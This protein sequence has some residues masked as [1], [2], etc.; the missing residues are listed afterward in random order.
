M[1]KWLKDFIQ[2]VFWM[3]IRNG[4]GQVMNAEFAQYV[5]V[6]VAMYMI[7]MEGLCAGA[8]YTDPQFIG[9]LSLLAGIIGIKEYF[10]GK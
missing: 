4:N 8:Q 2:A 1:I 5:T 7:V 9:V 3:P 6:W 10:K